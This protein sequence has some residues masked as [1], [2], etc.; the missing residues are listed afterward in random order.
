MASWC[1]TPDFFK[2]SAA[3][4][5][6]ASSLK[7]AK[8]SVLFAMDVLLSH[9]ANRGNRQAADPEPNGLPNPWLFSHGT[10]ASRTLRSRRSASISVTGMAELTGCTADTSLCLR[11]AEASRLGKAGMRTVIHFSTGLLIHRCTEAD[12]PVWRKPPQA[13][14][15]DASLAG[16]GLA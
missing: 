6:D 9:A 13:Y 5:A 8:T 3:L 11:T 12:Q 4:S 16:P 2:A 7:I 10:S 15:Q 14:A 1:A